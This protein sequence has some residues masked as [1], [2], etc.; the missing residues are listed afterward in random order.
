VATGFSSFIG[1]A[2]P[3][4]LDEWSANLPLSSYGRVVHHSGRKDLP[5]GFDWRGDQRKLAAGTM[6][7]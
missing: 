6:A 4:I 3:T 1:A 5:R 2:D 7:A